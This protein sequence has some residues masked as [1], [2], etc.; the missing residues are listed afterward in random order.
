MRINM[1]IIV[2]NFHNQDALQHII[3]IDTVLHKW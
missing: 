1:T 2:T 3:F